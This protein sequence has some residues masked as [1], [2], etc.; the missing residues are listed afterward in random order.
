VN[1]KTE[2]S[3]QLI[4]VLQAAFHFLEAAKLDHQ[5]VPNEDAKSVLDSVG[6][7]LELQDSPILGI[8]NYIRNQSLRC[9][10]TYCRTRK[11]ANRVLAAIDEA[12]AT[13]DRPLLHSLFVLLAETSHHLLCSFNQ[14]GKTYPS[15]SP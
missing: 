11:H 3:L 9:S 13:G 5:R 15:H 6:Q 10:L 7:L 8:G 14:K 1:L 4:T 2:S 12:V